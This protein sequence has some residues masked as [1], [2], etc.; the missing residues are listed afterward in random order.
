MYP[1]PSDIHELDEVAA[2]F[3]RG[4]A[5]GVLTN[6]EIARVAAE[7][8]LDDADLDELRTRLE[9]ADV[10]LV[11]ELDDLADPALPGRARKASPAPDLRAAMTTDSLQLFMKDIGRAR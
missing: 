6:G 3:A 8:E 9:A 7:V 5:A 2:L 4:Q 1:T 11:D 10:E